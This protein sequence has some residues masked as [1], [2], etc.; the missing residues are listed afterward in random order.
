[1]VDAGKVRTIKGRAGGLARA[2]AVQ[3]P[4]RKAPARKRTDSTSI[5][6]DD[7]WE[8]KRG[9]LVP[10]RGRPPRVRPLF[11]ALGEKLPF[12]SLGDVERDMRKHLG[13][14]LNGIYLAHDSMGQ[15][16]YIGRGQIFTRLR[17]RRAT[18]QLEL[19]Y[20]SFYIMKNKNHEREVET[21]LIRAVGLQSY[22][23]QRKKQDTILAGDVRDF[24]PGTLY[25]ERKFHRGA[26]P[27]L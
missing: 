10:G 11:V 7:E 6:G 15:V 21:V 16:R 3:R 5:Y 18:Q 4:K 1:L 26:R 23:N 20:F 12:G 22:F 9:R 2:A 13:P 14:G 24:E 19:T 8:V 27:K 25:Y 17:A